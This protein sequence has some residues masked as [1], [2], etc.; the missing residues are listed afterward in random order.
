MLKKELSKV[1]SKQDRAFIQALCFGTLRWYFRL[2]FIL[3]KLLQRPL[4][5]KD[6]DIRI[7][8]L[9]GI[10]QLCFTRV[11]AHAAVAETVAAAGKKT[12]AKPLLNGVLRTYQRDRQRLDDLVTKDWIARTSHPR[13]L[14]EKTA[15]DWPD[16][17]EDVLQQNNQAPPMVLRVNQLRLTRENYLELL[18]TNGIKATVLEFCDSGLC[19]DTPMDTEKLPGFAEGLASVQDGAA[20]QAASLM[21]VKAGSRVLDACA[22]PGGK[23][24]HILELCPE[25][26]EIVAVDIDP[27][28]LDRLRSN[29]NRT[30]LHATLVTG[31]V[32]SPSGW[33]DGRLFDRILLDVPCSATGVIRRHP[34]I[35]LLRLPED[36]GDLVRL[37]QKLLESVWPM[38]A[39]G[40]ILLYATCSIFKQENEHQ[41]AKFKASHGNAEEIP[42]KTAWGHAQQY[43]RQILPGDSTMDGFYYALLSKG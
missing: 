26:E 28:R 27:V 10:F 42:I 15:R 5:A 16:R 41:I 13:W 14:V 25:L 29:L 18:A 35:K 36:I 1:P 3:N 24:L 40:G 39:P 33:W 34:D 4:K 9:L 43:G 2:D 23:T 11:K 37:Q 21:D 30:G 22:A 20:Q 19:L 12:W 31:D 8:A 32:T 7:L 38:L 17:I 6:A